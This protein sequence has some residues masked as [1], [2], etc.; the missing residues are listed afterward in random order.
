MKEKIE[1]KK[2]ISYIFAVVIWI[3]FIYSA[4][5]AIT[6]HFLPFILRGELIPLVRGQ[7]IEN[8]LTPYLLVLDLGLL[9]FLKWLYKKIPFRP[10]SI[11]F[12]W[13][14]KF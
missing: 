10:S 5:V 12:R 9:Y 4:I 6:Q 8:P 14:E 1:Y 7:P 13:L 11:I 2:T 3:A